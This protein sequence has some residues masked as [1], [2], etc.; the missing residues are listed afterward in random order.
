MRWHARRYW[1]R[2]DLRMLKSPTLVERLVV[3]RAEQS[4]R[5]ARET[6]DK[7]FFDA[8]GAGHMGL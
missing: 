1:L 3:E 5:G 2:F 6:G 4:Y 7:Q 8:R